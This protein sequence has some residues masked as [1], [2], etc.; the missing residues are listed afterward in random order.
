[1]AASTFKNHLLRTT[2][3]F[4]FAP[5]RAGPRVS[6]SAPEQATDGSLPQAIGP[7][8]TSWLSNTSYY[9]LL[10]TQAATHAF[11]LCYEST[12][13]TVLH[14]HPEAIDFLQDPL[15]HFL[16]TTLPNLILSKKSKNIIFQLSSSSTTTIYLKHTTFSSLARALHSTSPTP[17]LFSTS[18]SNFD[19]L[20]KLSDS[21]SD[22]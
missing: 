22:A 16:H 1:M 15:F 9:I 2:T 3:P 6:K 10:S 11:S 17:S 12:S 4:F 7:Y 21:L 8:S 18:Q 5:P 19:S 20:L 14:L 13:P